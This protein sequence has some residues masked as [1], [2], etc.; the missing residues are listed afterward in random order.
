MRALAGQRRVCALQELC[1]AGGTI[2]KALIFLPFDHVS[3]WGSLAHAE[4]GKPDGWFGT[5]KVILDYV[6]IWASL[7]HEVPAAAS[8]LA[9]QHLS[10]H[11]YI[12]KLPDGRFFFS[13]SSSGSLTTSPMYLTLSLLSFLI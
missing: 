9:P 1:I 6:S 12:L 4:V 13:R 7:L 3:I 5:I 2:Q 11:T 8:L 10:L